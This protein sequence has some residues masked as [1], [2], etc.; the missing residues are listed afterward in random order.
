MAWKFLDSAK[1][2][3][4]RYRG[5]MKHSID[6]WWAHF[7]NKRK[8]IESMLDGKTKWDL[9]EFMAESLQS[10]DESLM[11]EFGTELD[12]KYQ[13]VITPETERYLRPLVESIIE[14]APKISTWSFFGYRQ[15]HGTEE[16]AE[17]VVEQTGIKLAD[18]R[19][20][21]RMDEEHLIDVRFA[22]VQPKSKESLA[23]A[24]FMASEYLIGEE[25]LD[26]WIGDMEIDAENT[27]DFKPLSELPNKIASLIA[28]TQ[29]TMPEQH[30]YNVRDSLAVTAFTAEPTEEDDDT[31]ERFD[32]V[33]AQTRLKQV[34]QAAHSGSPFDSCRFSKHGEKFCYLKLQGLTDSA[35]I[36]SLESAINKAL[37]EKKLGCTTG[38]AVGKGHGYIDLCLQDVQQAIPLLRKVCETEAKSTR[39]WLQ[40]FDADWASE[41]VAIGGEASTPPGMIEH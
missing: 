6:A 34:W 39:G 2:A 25:I 41:W 38:S 18:L 7:Q 33:S 21:A 15:P 3:S 13:L 24:V 17:I 10:I 30:L 12:N 16:T 11:W 8:N 37:G 29:A 26:R 36:D 1:P 27:T 35:K 14:S 31:T 9:E 32:M 40:F 19:F 23:D 20:D 22:H 5:E 4:E 28:Q